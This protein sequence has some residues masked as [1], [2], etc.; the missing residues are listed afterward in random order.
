MNPLIVSLSQ[1]ARSGKALLFRTDLALLQ[2]SYREAVEKRLHHYTEPADP[3]Q[4][5]LAGDRLAYRH[6]LNS[7]SV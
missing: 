7:F 1:F 6:R 5:Q 2:S 3:E 4:L